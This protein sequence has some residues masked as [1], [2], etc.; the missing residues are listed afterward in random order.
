VRYDEDPPRKFYSLKAREIERLNPARGE[1][2]PPPALPTDIKEHLA[3]AAAAPPSP[4]STRPDGAFPAPPLN[5][6][7]QLV[8]TNAL[9]E[10]A[11]GLNDVAI[12]RPKRPSRR[13]RD[14]LF[15]MITGNCLILGMTIIAG[16]NLVSLVFSLAGL[17]LF[18]ASVTWIMWQVMDDY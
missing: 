13:K 4:G 1:A 11:A 16:L 15:A 18:N 12:G 8:Q 5:D 17:I 6:V 10:H 9:K 14:Y 7:Q 2:S 3:R